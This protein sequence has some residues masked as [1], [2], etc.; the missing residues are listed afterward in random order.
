MVGVL[1]SGWLTTGE[2]CSRFEREFCEAVGTAHAVAMSSCTAA[3]HA[4]LVALGVGPGDEFITT[5]FTFPATANAIAYTGAK[6]VLVDVQE[7]TGNLEMGRVRSVIESCYRYRQVG[8]GL[9]NKNT[10]RV[11]KGILPVHYGGE[12]CN[13]SELLHIAAEFSLIVVEDAAH[14]LGAEMDDKHA[15]SFGKAGCFSFYPTKAITTAEGGMVA[16]NDA[17]LAACLRLLRNHGLTRESWSRYG[18]KAA[19]H[20]DVKHLGFKYNMTDI[21][22][23]LGI[24]QLR[25]LDEFLDR[26]RQLA[27][28]YDAG[29]VG[30][31]GIRTLESDRVGRSAKHLY[32]ILVD[33]SVT[34]VDRDDLIALLRAE[35]IGT[36]VHFIPLHLHSYYEAI[37]GYRRG[38]FPNAEA[39]FQRV[40]SLPLFPGMKD[41]D[42]SRVVSCIDGAMQGSRRP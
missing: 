20:Y 18:A 37:S 34:G 15:G 16:T 2:V 14:A 29:L 27:D 11:L 31:P 10:G 4:C 24:H 23:A 22:A 12:L 5:P 17:E 28:K 1:R 19:W 32:V 39:L 41:D 33:G 36:S 13:M 25:R 3:M 26:R 38:D 9:V 21:Q 8:S 30:I 35:G 7:E 6:P 42:V 40:V